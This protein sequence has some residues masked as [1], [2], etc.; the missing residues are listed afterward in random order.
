MGMCQIGEN[1]I[2]C[3]WSLRSVIA[4]ITWKKPNITHIV[5]NGD[6]VRFQEHQKTCDNS[7]IHSL[8]CHDH[9]YRYPISNKN[10]KKGKT[11]RSEAALLQ[12]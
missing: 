9:R 2:C 11:H 10:A 3:D 5:I 1:T 7:R 8:S 6:N 12:Q 4:D